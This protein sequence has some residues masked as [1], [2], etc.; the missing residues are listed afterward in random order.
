MPSLLRLLILEDSP[1]DAGVMVRHLREAGYAPDWQRVETEAEFLAHLEP[2][3]DL[4]LI[5]YTLPDLKG[6]RALRDP[7]RSRLGDS[8]YH[9]HRHRQ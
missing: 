9:R 8:V 2:N 3:L 7:A 4:L 5:D 6:R 1:T